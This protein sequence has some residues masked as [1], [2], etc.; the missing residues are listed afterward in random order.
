MKN[1][2]LACCALVATTL[3]SSYTADACS[4]V[5][6]VGTDHTVVTGRTMDWMVSLKTN[7]WMF[8]VGIVRSGAAG[9]N[10]LR[11]TSK[12]GSVVSAAYDAASTDGMNQKGLVANLLYLSTA[13]YEA[14]D[15]SKPALSLAGWPQY[16]LDNYVTV[17][18]AVAGLQ[19]EEFQIVAPPMPGGYAPT[20]H[21]SISDVTGDSAIFEYIDGKLIIHHDPKYAVMTNEPSFDKQLALDEY[22]REIG[23]KVM[24]PGTDR[25]A[26]RFVR[27]S[28]YLDQSI[29][30]ADTRTSIAGVF[31]IMRNVSV[32]MGVNNPDSPNIAPT[33][34]R[35]VS[36][37][38]NLV[39]YFESVSSPNVV[40]VDFSKLNLAAGQ[41]TRELDL[42]T[43]PDLSGE[44]STDF[45][46]ASAF[47]FM[48]AGG[49]I[50]K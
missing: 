12:Y 16:V 28:Y 47:K 39:Y 13:Q 44:V 21:L 26:D 23:G 41:P 50:A 20:M 7:L 34:W 2:I 6:Y 22:W 30:T 9:P 25:P 3:T 10:S 4:R 31:S 42:Q 45:R 49:T 38:K 32:P 5:V 24:L 11:W 27:A 40:W 33:L 1:S 35:T 36:D 14:R 37:Q 8:P 18:E 17:A 29:K 46:K 43:G 19:K 48:D 15:S